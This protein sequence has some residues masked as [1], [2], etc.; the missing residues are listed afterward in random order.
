[1]NNK[2]VCSHQNKVRS[3]TDKTSKEDNHYE[4]RQI[5]DVILSIFS[6]KT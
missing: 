6:V 5:V 4:N 2:E 3:L 1:M